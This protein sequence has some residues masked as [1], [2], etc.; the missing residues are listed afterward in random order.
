MVRGWRLSSDEAME[1][2]LAKTIRDCLDAV[3]RREH[4]DQAVSAVGVQDNEQGGS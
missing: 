3:G 1:R 2:Y 4:A